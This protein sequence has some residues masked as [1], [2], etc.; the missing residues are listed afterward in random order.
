VPCAASLQFLVRSGKVHAILNM[1]SNDAIWGKPY[2][3]FLFTMLQ[4]LL[5]CELN[6]EMGTYTHSAASIHLYERHFDLAN[7]I[8]RSD[9]FVRFEMPSMKAHHQLPHFL[10]MEASIR[11]KGLQNQFDSL[12]LDDYWRHLLMVLT[13]FSNFR[14]NGAFSSEIPIP[15][16]FP[17][18]QLLK[19]SLPASSGVK[20]Q[21][22]MNW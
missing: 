15:T 3:I 1:R 5:A 11:S 12:C 7:K 20:V 17:Y 16:G 14:R 13:W 6:L 22:N 2:D 10:E 4:E 21:A 19:N 8:V 18:L 9:Q